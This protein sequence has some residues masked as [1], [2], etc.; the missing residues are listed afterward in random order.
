MKALFVGAGGEASQSLQAELEADG[1]RDAIRLAGIRFD[2]PRLMLAS[3]LL[4][5]PSVAEGL[6]MVAVEAQAAGLRVLASDSTP[7]ECAVVPE[8]VIFVSLA[9]S[10]VKWADRAAVLLSAPA[11]DRDASRAAVERSPF[12][13]TSS[14][15]ALLDA[16]GFVPA[17]PS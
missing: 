6:G 7:R 13:I 12:S 2:V 1:L 15:M 10:P 17:S 11:P 3:D 9:E 16:Y 4:L 14:V 8:M 5:F